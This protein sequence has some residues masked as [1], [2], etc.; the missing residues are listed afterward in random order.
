MRTRAPLGRDGE[1]FV[2]NV[3]A[4]VFADADRL[5]LGYWG[6]GVLAG[7]SACSVSTTD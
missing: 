4:D 3:V 7:R 6:G 1:R 5:L 2:G